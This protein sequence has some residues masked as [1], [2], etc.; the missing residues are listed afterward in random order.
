MGVEGRLESPGE[1]WKG[2]R[3]QRLESGTTPCLESRVWSSSLSKPTYVRAILFSPPPLRLFRYS[4]CHEQWWL[5]LLP[6]ISFCQKSFLSLGTKLLRP[7]RE[8]MITVRFLNTLNRTISLVFSNSPPLTRYP[9]PT[10]WFLIVKYF[11]VLNILLKLSTH[12][13]W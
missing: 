10:G 12:L 8:L 2:A 7:A 6:T 5:P 9:Y 3:M 13:K 11:V 4:C 1:P